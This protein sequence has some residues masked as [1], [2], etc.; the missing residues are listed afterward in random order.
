MPLSLNYRLRQQARRATKR[1]FSLAELAAVMAIGTTITAFAVPIMNS[2]MSSVKKSQCIQRLHNLHQGVINYCSDNDGAFPF[3]GLN[4]VEDEERWHRRIIPY[5]FPT[6]NEDEFRDRARQIYIC[7]ADKSP[8]QN[9]VSYGMN[10]DL[11]EK[12]MQSL[13]GARILLADAKD[14]KITATETKVS[15]FR[16]DHKGEGN[17]VM[18]DGSC[19]QYRNLPAAAA[20]P[21]LWQP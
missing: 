1:G 8:F 19:R 17:V 4:K 9:F 11:A 3:S 6:A 16:K 10:T 18:T 13:A 15:T 2:S 14:F 7:P 12:R 20:A 21:E 5:M